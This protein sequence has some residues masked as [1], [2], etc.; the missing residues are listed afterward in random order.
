[1]T[2]ETL[3][4]GDRVAARAKKKPRSSTSAAPKKAPKSSRARTPAKGRRA[5]HL[6]GSAADQGVRSRPTE[7]PRLDDRGKEWTR[8]QVEHEVR[9]IVGT[10]A[11]VPLGDVMLS[12]RFQEDL[13]WDEWF[14][15]SLLKPIKRRLHEDLADFILLQLET[16]GD[17]LSYVWARMEVPA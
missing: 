1:M 12:T 14:I 5:A 9:S 2:N 6:V 11:H 8:Q 4:K 3:P 13:D 10:A 17:L 15:L 16:V 7:L